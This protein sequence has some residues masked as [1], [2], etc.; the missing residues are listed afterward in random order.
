M[1]HVTGATYTDPCPLGCGVRH[2]FIDCPA[3]RQQ[4]PWQRRKSIDTA[5]RCYNCFC[6]HRTTECQ[7][8]NQCRECGSRHHQLLNCITTRRVSST[9]STQR[10]STTSTMYP[11]SASFTPQLRSATSTTATQGFLGHVLCQKDIPRFSPT[12]YVEISDANGVWHRIVAFFDSGSDTT[13]IKSSLARRLGLVGT[14][15]L[16]H[17]G[18]AGGGSKTDNNTRYM[19]QVRPVHIRESIAY[20][21]EAMGINRPAHDAPAIDETVFEEFQY[22]QPAQGYMP[23]GG[24]SI[25]LLVGYDHAYLIN[26]LHTIPSS[27]N[28]DEHPRAAF[29]RLGWTIFGGMIPQPR[30]V[31]TNRAEINHV[32]RLVEED[33]K[34]LFYSD[35]AAVKPTTACAC[36]DH[37]FAEAKFLIHARRTTEIDYVYHSGAIPAQRTRLKCTLVPRNVSLVHM[38]TTTAVHIIQD[39]RAFEPASTQCEDDYRTTK[40][41]Q[42]PTAEWGDP[43]NFILFDK[44][45]AQATSPNAPIDNE[46]L[47]NCGN[48]RNC[49]S[50]T[51]ISENVVDATIEADGRYCHDATREVTR[52]NNWRNRGQVC[53]GRFS[54]SPNVDSLSFRRQ[55]QGRSAQYKRRITTKLSGE[56]CLYYRTRRES[57]LHR[58]IGVLPAFRRNPCTP[59][60]LSAV[61]TVAAVVARSPPPSSRSP[62]PLSRSSPPFS[63]SPPSLF[64]SPPPLSRSS[65]PSSRRSLDRRRRCL[66]RRPVVSP[67]SRSPPSFSRSPPPSSRSPPPLS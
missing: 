57:M 52:E 39:T 5:G 48:I 6:R 45:L 67:F 8:P 2:K 54:D 14:R 43:T 10:T 25:D 65:P 50:S 26:A 47:Y 3:F 7:K 51:R 29:S 16:F 12:T 46:Q 34:A 21:V 63:R 61:S 1:H 9:P 38:T 64:R 58:H 30:P 31:I 41:S 18:V 13:L 22:L 53:L 35:V 24:A 62:P 44:R 4:Q 17:Y 37:E 20:A 56:K 40:I 49:E 33:T 15:E 60:L 27:T 42:Q 36:S 28:A 11:S 55:R 59:P 19:L 66:N 23:V 32:Q